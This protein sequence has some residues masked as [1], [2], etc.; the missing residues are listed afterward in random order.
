[1]Q[2]ATSII[3][4]NRFVVAKEKTDLAIPHRQPS[5]V[6]S[7]GAIHAITLDN[8][9]ANK[10][11]TPVIS[12]PIGVFNPPMPDVSTKKG[13]VFSD[14]F[15]KNVLWYLPVFS[16]LPG[17]DAGFSFIAKQSVLPNQEGDPFY[18]ADVRFTVH[19]DVPPDAMA[20]KAANAAIQLKEIMLQSL[21][22]TLSI[23][24]SDAQG[25]ETSA[26]YTGVLQAS[27]DGNYEVHVSNILGNHVVILYQNLKTTGGGHL[28]LS[29]IYAAWRPAGSQRMIF[30][31]PTVSLNRVRPWIASIPAASPTTHF[32]TLRPLHPINPNVGFTENQTFFQNI[33]L[34]TKYNGNEY[35]LSYKIITDTGTR[36]IVGVEDLKNLN[37]NPTEFSELKTIDLSKYPSISALY[38]GVL[39]RVIIIL[40]R[41]YGIVRNAVTCSASCWASV[42]TTPGGT[43]G[44]CMFQFQFELTPAVNPV[45]FIMLLKEIQQNTELQSYTLKFADS[46]DEKTPSVINS[47]F[48]TDTSYDQAATPQ[49]FFLT[50]TN[51]DKPGQSAV[52]NANLFI[53]QLCNTP[54]GCAIGSM[55][56]KLDDNFPKELTTTVTLS[57]PAAISD[58][59]ITWSI[60]PDKQTVKL[61][62]STSFNFLLQRYTFCSDAGIGDTTEVNIPIASGDS[63]TVP[64]P[65]NFDHLSII[66]DYIEQPNG[67]VNRSNIARYMEIKAQDAQNV[68][69]FIGVNSSQVK[70]A[71]RGIKQ[72]DVQIFL[73]TFTGV[74]VPKFTVMNQNTAG[75]TN[76]MLPLQFAITSLPATINLLVTFSD[77]TKQPISFTK[78]NDFI[79]NPVLDILDTDIP[80]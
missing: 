37:G 17:T 28:A 38:I 52:V 19:K 69:Y 65:Q 70:Y 11:F 24:F 10:V 34:D 35:Q 68:Q 39:S 80:P 27:T 49:N 26:T 76:I 22:V 48:T 75:G 13:N 23:A 42:D 74:S 77:T 62:N 47:V 64:L 4:R 46:L 29:A 16:L 9:V 33:P 5:P 20:A 32:T 6:K 15:D 71:A 63:T 2:P 72:M 1:M 55:N 59:G 25:K 45:D 41:A 57:L 30:I 44:S 54:P 7:S 12:I 79:V 73:T 14:R 8:A 66:L 31:K 78:E 51:V 36:P 60:D 40:P 50:T 18:V 53:Q 58:D 67:G 56:L 3:A 61:T 43:A 21:Q